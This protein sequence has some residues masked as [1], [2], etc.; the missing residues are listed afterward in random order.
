[1]L[2]QHLIE[3]QTHRHSREVCQYNYNGS[4]VT[5]TALANS[6]PN[7]CFLNY[8]AMLGRKWL[9]FSQHSVVLPWHAFIHLCV[10]C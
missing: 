2:N 8:R 6:M 10:W 7:S 1:M 5:L 3:K 4:L 9:V